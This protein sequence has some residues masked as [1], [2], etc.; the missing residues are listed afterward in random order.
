MRAKAGPDGYRRWKRYGMEAGMEFQRENRIIKCVLDAGELILK[1]GGE[2]NRV[3]DT[4]TRMFQAYGFLRADV[5][6]ITSSIV[7]TVYTAQ[8]AILTQTRRIYGYDTNLQRVALVNQLAREVCASPIGVEELECRLEEIDWSRE[9][10]FWFKILLYGATAA[11]FA[12]FYSGGVLEAVFAAVTGMGICLL[13]RLMQQAVSNAIV[14]YAA[15]SAVGGL[16]LTL[17]QKCG[18]SFHIDPAMMGNI[19]LLIP[20]LP[21]MNAIRE[22]LAGDT[23]SGLL[24]LC[25]SLIRTIAIAAGFIGA[26]TLMGGGLR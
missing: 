6:T 18:I 10:P 21:F 4:M 22:M 7:V 23:M 20:G 17:V 3:E 16:F 1:S 24:R 13:L 14:R 2:I 11:V 19:M 25:E 26:M 8:G 9:W 15:C 5:F 12:V